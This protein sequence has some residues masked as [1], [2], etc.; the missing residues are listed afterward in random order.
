M[1]PKSPILRYLPFALSR[2]RAARPCRSAPA[3]WTRLAR[4]S[5]L[6][7]LLLAPSACRRSPVG[8]HETVTISGTVLTAS[9]APD[10][11]RRIKLYDRDLF[12]ALFFLLIPLIAPVETT[13]SDGAG[14]YAMNVSG[15]LAN[16]FLGARTFALE[17]DAGGN[18][19]SVSVS[20]KLMQ[21]QVAVPTTRLWDGNGR[22]T[23]GPA[24]IVFAWDDIAAHTGFAPGFHNVELALSGQ[25]WT[26][27]PGSSTV[28]SV[29]RLAFQEFDVSWRPW[30]YVDT[31]GS[32]TKFRFAFRG[33]QRRLG[34]LNAAP[35]SRGQSAI[36]TP[37]GS[38]TSAFTDGVLASTM[39]QSVTGGARVEL[40]L[41]QTRSLT[42]L[43]F[44]DL[45]APSTNDVNVSV[46]TIAGG[47][48]TRIAVLRRPPGSGLLVEV[49][50][51]GVTARYITI[52][53]PV[54]EGLGEIV[55]Y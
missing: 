14:G 55:V 41:G 31:R 18:D 43:F 33:A 52:E 8:A 37:P 25:P 32:G 29:R 21:T 2:T 44:F 10:S 4:A 35:P 40:D 17:P 12:D 6:L 27:T 48:R 13:R 28:A 26:L 45:R 46:G 16:G 7:L 3:T 49:P 22:A 9:G 15:A 47:P 24:D 50:V 30:G 19:P 20:F 54:L 1:T 11:G 36:L 5:A 38:A 23:A 34:A 39:P 42:A 51:L 53:T